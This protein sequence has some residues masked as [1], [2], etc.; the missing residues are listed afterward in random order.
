MENTKQQQS[1]HLSAA[2][3]AQRFIEARTRQ[4]APP[5]VSPVS[6][7][8]LLSELKAWR[9]RAEEVPSLSLFCELIDYGFNQMPKQKE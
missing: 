6:M 7:T 9:I 5:V 8:E 3:L 1:N 2:D 4:E